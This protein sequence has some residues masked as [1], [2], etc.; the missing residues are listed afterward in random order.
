MMQNARIGTFT[1]LLLLV[2]LLCAPGERLA[3]QTT[4]TRD[5]ISGGGATVEGTGRMMRGT[6][7]QTAVGRLEG[8]DA[9]VER[10]YAGFWYW[11]YRPDV[12]TTVTL[13]RIETTTRSRITLDL[14]LETGETERPF[15]PRPYTVRIRFNGTLLH[16]LEG[17]PACEYDGDDCIV[18]IRDTALVENGVIG[19]FDF[20]T[21]LGNA[22][23][24]PLTIESFEWDLFGEERVTV[25]KVDGELTLLD[26]CREGDDIRLILSGPA[27]RLAVHP[28]PAFTAATL[29]LTP[30]ETGPVT[31][32]LV[33]GLGSERLRFS[34]VEVEAG[35]HYPV[36]LDLSGVA[37]GYYTVVVRTPS[38]ILT[39]QLI[40]QQ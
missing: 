31:I 9:G 20:I 11:A 16:P 15:V 3:A 1:V 35:R 33:D 22:V 29:D 4:I 2:G 7:S 27:A 28:N 40:I 24:T 8:S 10:H 17:T 19:R 21:A 5:V 18:E 13:P 39:R 26:V 38:E 6:L 25:T 23:S 37:S 34:P 14:R 32:S 36:Q 12:S 30:N